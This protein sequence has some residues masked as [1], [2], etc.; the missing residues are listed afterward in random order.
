MTSIHVSKYLIILFDHDSNTILVK[1]LKLSSAQELVRAYEVLHAH[2]CDHGLRPLFHITDNACPARLKQFMNQEGVDFQLVPPH[3]HCTNVAKRKI[4]TYKDHLVTRL[5]SCN[6]SFT[7]Q[8]WDRLMQNATLTLNLLRPSGINSRLSVDAQ[9]NGALELN[10]T[11]LAPPGTKVLV[12]KTPDQQ[13]TW[14]P[15][16]IDGWYLGSAMEHYRCY[17]V[18]I[19]ATRAEH[20]AKT[21]QLYPASCAMPTTLSADAAIGSARALAD[22]L[23]HPTSAAP[24]AKFGNSQL[25]A[26]EDLVRIFDQAIV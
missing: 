7:L 1:P 5:S 16:G 19:P 26:I 3:L 4:Q 22:A 25:R 12:Y 8:L 9:L 10:R 18:Y 21:V 11:P 6:P 23:L 14:Y 24:F 15:H 17:Q 20:I 13:H 2:L